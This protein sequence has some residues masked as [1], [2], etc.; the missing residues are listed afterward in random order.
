[1]PLKGIPCF[2]MRGGTTKGVLFKKEDLPS[3]EKTRDEVILKIFGSGDPFQLDGLGGSRTVSSKVMIV[4][5]SN[6]GDVDVE[7]MFGQVGIEEWSIDWSGNCGNLTTAVGCFAI[8]A[9]LVKPVEPFTVVRMYNVNT[10]KRIDAVIPIKNGQI[11]YD[12]DYYIDGIPRPGSRID[13]I[14]H[15]PGGTMT[16][17]LLPTGNERD[18]VVVEGKGIEVTIVDAANPAVFVKAEDVGLKGT[19]LPNQIDRKTLER[20]EAI[21][22][23]AAEM[24]GL[25]ERAEEAMI[26][27]PHFPYIIVVSDK[28]DYYTVQ[29]NLV[30]KECYTLLARLFSLQQMHHAYPVTGAICTASAAKIPGTVVSDVAEDR[31][32][33]VIIG[34]PKGLIDVKIRTGRV[35]GKTTVVTATIGR[36]ARKLMTGIA[37]YLE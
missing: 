35:A 8:E 14:W 30:K 32:E 29:G 31:G 26:K 20:L 15:D 17:A 34:H 16:R 19:E 1:M 13:L 25:V 9:N 4:W 24:C 22:S 33:L 37:Y 18:R 36:T 7:Y 10:R 11:V 6:R 2:L 28:K 21:R 3:D 5:K 12:G 23:R 27:S